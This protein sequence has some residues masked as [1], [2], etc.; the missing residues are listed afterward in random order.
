MSQNRLPDYVQHMQQAAADACSFVEGLGKDDFLQDK[1]TQQ[2]DITAA[3]ANWHD[4]QQR[5]KTP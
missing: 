5:R 1:R 2:A 4:W 3:L